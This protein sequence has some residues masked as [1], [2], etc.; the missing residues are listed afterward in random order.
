MFG[1]QLPLQY[2]GSLRK[3]FQTAAIPERLHS[4][5]PQ[6]VLHRLQTLAVQLPLE[7]HFVAMPSGPLYLFVVSEQGN[8][9]RFAQK[10]IHRQV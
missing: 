5:R 3:T 2:F 1:D 6:P 7:T 10:G 4:P 8:V 9:T